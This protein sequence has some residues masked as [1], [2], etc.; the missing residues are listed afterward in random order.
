LGYVIPLVS[1]KATGEATLADLGYP[2][3]EI[4]ARLREEADMLLI[5]PKNAGEKGNK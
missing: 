4:E 2:G 1:D 5:T 3:K